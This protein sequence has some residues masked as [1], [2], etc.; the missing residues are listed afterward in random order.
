MGLKFLYLRLIYNFHIVWVN[1]TIFWCWALRSS[2]GFYARALKKLWF[3]CCCLYPIF[4]FFYLWHRVP[5]K[6]RTAVEIRQSNAILHIFVC[7]DWLKIC[8]DLFLDPLYCRSSSIC[9]E[10][11]LMMKWG[12]HSCGP[13]G[14]K[15]PNLWMS[16]SSPKASLH[17][18]SVMGDANTGSSLGLG[19]GDGQLFSCCVEQI[20]HGRETWI[21]YCGWALCH[22]FH[23]K[24]KPEI[25]DG[26]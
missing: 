24:A 2:E 20:S 6:S 15:V 7:L 12:D 11:R 22:C 8:R 25:D 18:E 3:S 16:E 17:Q 10:V 26:W 13:C 9:S 23:I 14:Q 21:F 4:S 5:Q 19:W 1:A